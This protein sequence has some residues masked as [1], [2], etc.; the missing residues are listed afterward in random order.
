MVQMQLIWS[1]LNITTNDETIIMTSICYSLQD[2][3][4]Y[5]HAALWLAHH[6]VGWRKDAF[7]ITPSEV[8]PTLKSTSLELENITIVKTDVNPILKNDVIFP[9]H[10]V[11]LAWNTWKPEDCTPPCSPPKIQHAVGRVQLGHWQKLSEETC[12]GFEY[13]LSWMNRNQC[14]EWYEALKATFAE[15]A[16]NNAAALQTFP[17]LIPH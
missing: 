10:A 7:V 5:F 14:D 12:D 9:L 8:I 13:F 6:R 11:P 17:R 15:S 1:H 2:E 3:D 4:K 16:V